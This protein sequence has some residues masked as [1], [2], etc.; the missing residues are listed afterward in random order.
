MNLLNDRYNVKMCN[1]CGM[2]RLEFLNENVLIV[3]K[4]GCLKLVEVKYYRCKLVLLVLRIESNI[5]RK[6]EL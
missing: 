1:Y 2:L 5:L 4:S 6:E 3:L